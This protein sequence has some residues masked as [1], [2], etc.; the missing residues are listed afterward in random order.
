VKPSLV[1]LKDGALL[2]EE[3]SR[4]L[5]VRFS[6]YM[7]AHEGDLA[8]FARQESWHSVSPEYRQG[9]AVLVVCTFPGAPTKSPKAPKAAAGPKPKPKAK[10]KSAPGKAPPSARAPGKP[11]PRR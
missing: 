4:A 2:P 9:Q 7:D 1:V 6:G 3:E 11:K 5:W 8:G 10:P